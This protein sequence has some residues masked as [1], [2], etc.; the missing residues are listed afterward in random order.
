VSSCGTGCIQTASTTQW[1]FAKL[2]IVKTCAPEELCWTQDTV[3]G[4]NGA[5]INSYDSEFEEA[6]AQGAIILADGTV[7]SSQ[8]GSGY[9]GVDKGGMQL[10]VDLNGKK[11]PNRLGRDIH[12]MVITASPTTEPRVVPYCA[13]GSSGFGTYSQTTVNNG[14]S[15]LGVITTSNRG[16]TCGA[17]WMTGD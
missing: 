6:K 9:S 4:L 2:N 17:K 15:G 10:Y 12:V 13:S 16:Y 14:C 7:I 8:T 1:L 3:L 11:G 5:D